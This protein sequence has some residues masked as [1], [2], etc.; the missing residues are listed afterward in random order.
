MKT[1]KKRSRKLMRLRNRERL[2]RLHNQQVVLAPI[3]ILVIV[4]LSLPYGNPAKTLDRLRLHIEKLTGNVNFPITNPTIAQ[5]TTL[6]DELDTT[7]VQVEAGNKALLP[8]RVTLTNQGVA[9]IRKLGY[10]IQDL[11]AGDEEKIRSAGFDIRKIG[12]ATLVPGQI[13]N[14]IAKPVG[15]GKI[16]LSWKRD[17]AAKVYVIEQFM[18]GSPPIPGPGSWENVGKTRNVSFVVEGLTPGQLY[19]FRVYGTNGNSDGNPSDPA[20]QRSL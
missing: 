19:Y 20:E 15:F 4:K 16:R 5:L 6:A 9:M 7:I 1:Q 13:L 14:L 10:N 3:F 18:N 12:G 11:S 8:H 17:G 2:N